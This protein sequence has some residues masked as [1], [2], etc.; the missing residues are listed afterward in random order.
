MPQTEVDA[1]E[2][3]IVELSSHI[4]AATARWLEDVAR[5]DASGVDFGER[6]SSAHWLAWRCSLSLHEARDFVRVARALDGLPKISAAFR[7]GQIS[8][9]KVSSLTKIATSEL[10]DTL[11][12]WAANGT[13]AQVHRI[14]TSYQQVLSAATLGEVNMRHAERYLHHFVNERGAFV[15]KGMLDPEE[16]AIIASALD[17]MMES[18][19]ND[20]D[21][22][23]QRRADAL[24]DVA[25]A[26][27]EASVDGS[28]RA[29]RYQVVLHVDAESVSDS[30]GDAGA[31]VAPDVPV[32]GETARRVMCDCSIVTMV[33]KAGEPIA[34]GRKSRRIPTS[35]RRA[36]LARDRGCR[37]PGCTNKRWVDGHHRTHWIRGGQTNLENLVA[38][39]RRHHRKTHEGEYEVRRRADDELEFVSRDGWIVE[40]SPPIGPPKEEHERMNTAV[41]PATYVD[42]C[43]YD[44]AVAALLP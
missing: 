10:E 32:H 4:N 20:E 37:W 15:I 6:Q 3:E 39:C 44:M 5:M 41:L 26:A 27:L 18:Q 40:A 29:D 43:D 25:Q 42:E 34:I 21:S 19:P 22:F 2:S 9:R 17:A 30:G 35:I 23:E 24:V 14:V 1:L 11:L 36:M 8:Y 13:A 33:E 7:A 38:L 28:H 12:M 16:G 31:E